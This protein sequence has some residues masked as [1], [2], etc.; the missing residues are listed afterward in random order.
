MSTDYVNEIVTEETYVSEYFSV[1]AL[2]WWAFG[3]AVY[4][5]T[6]TRISLG[7]TTKTIDKSLDCFVKEKQAQF[8]LLKTLKIIRN[9]TSVQCIQTF[10]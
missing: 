9:K 3:S 5:K 2:L 7:E 1:Q 8:I 6:K 4:G 10:D